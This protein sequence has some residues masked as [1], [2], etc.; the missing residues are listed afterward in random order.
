M[1]IEKPAQAGTL[2][3]ND[4][5]VQLLPHEGEGIEI[6]LKSV[7]IKQFGK[8]IRKVATQTLNAMGITECLCILD[9]KGALDYTITARIESAVKRSIC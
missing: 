2:E 6:R 4:I 5:Y 3:S 1:K 8:Q 9:D 7:V